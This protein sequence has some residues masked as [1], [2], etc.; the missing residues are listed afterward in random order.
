MEGTAN[1]P[2][3]SAI[4]RGLEPTA[5]DALKAATEEFEGMFLSYLLKV[6]RSTLESE[7]ENELSMGKDIY[8]SMF[9]NEIAL[10]IARTRSLGIGEMMY[11]QLQEGEQAGRHPQQSSERPSWTGGVARSAEVVDQE[12][13]FSGSTTPSALNKEASQYLLD[14]AATPPV[15]EGQ[16]SVAS[17]SLPVEGRLSSTFGLRLDPITGSP[18]F[19]KGIDIA[20]PGGTPFRAASGGTVVFAGMLNGYGNTV[21][22][23]HGNGSRTLYGHASQ[24]LV[25]A[26]DAVSPGQPV[27]LV[28]ATGRATGPHL[29]FETH[30]DGQQL[31]PQALIALKDLNKVYNPIQR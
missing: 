30:L 10:T 2:N 13:I 19:H 12:K 25:Q 9:D 3:V 5:R 16:S 27:G 14:R 24:I 17:M 22:I 28:G 31:D 20:A 26:G 18:R 1:T 8:T 23:E 4:Q 11:R 29:H 6:M 21:V 7:D 15:Q